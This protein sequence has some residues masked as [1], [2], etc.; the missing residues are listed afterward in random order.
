MRKVVGIIQARMGASRLP[1]KMMLWLNGHPVI[2]WVVKRVQS[3]G[4][5]DRVVVALPSGARDDV[6]AMYLERQ[7]VPVF[8]GSE[9][10]L[11]DRFYQ[12]ARAVCATHIVR[13]C[14]DNPL[15]CGSEI[16]HLV[17][18][19]FSHTNDYVYNHI[20]RNNRYPDGLGAEIISFDVLERVWNEARKPEHR[21]HLLN[22]I[23]ENPE[24]FSIGTFDPPDPELAKPEVKL[25]ID[26]LEDYGKILARPVRIE[27]TAREILAAFKE[28]SDHRL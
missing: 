18:Y 13:I 23:W 15:I 28:G 21:E 22:Y 4:K 8:R 16:D 25:D 17:D 11:V 6:L 9:T 3:A 24:K 5:L 27:M 26:L 20:P 10:D 1:N 2:D 12:A 7:G 19:Y 14:A